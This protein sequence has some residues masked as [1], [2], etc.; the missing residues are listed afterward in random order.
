[1][2]NQLRLFRDA[3][4]AL[5]CSRLQRRAKQV[6]GQYA[7]GAAPP[8][9]PL[10]AL[11]EEQARLALLRRANRCG[12]RLRLAQFVTSPAGAQ[13]QRTLRACIRRIE[14]LEARLLCA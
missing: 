4:P 3:S 11:A 10:R 14:A 6:L 8:S 7:A 12:S 1:M 13:T 5:R 9:F 2:A